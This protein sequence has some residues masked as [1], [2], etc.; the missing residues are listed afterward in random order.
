MKKA[1]QIIS[2]VLLTAVF[3]LPFQGCGKYEEGPSFSLKTK[4]GR[5][6]QSWTVEKFVDHHGDETTATGNEGTYTYEKDGTYSWSDGSASISGT[7]EFDDSKENI[8]TTLTIIIAV[9][10][11]TKIIKLTSSELWIEDSDGDQ[12]HFKAE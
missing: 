6:C 2:L 10:T 12:A 8:E 3:T 1:L 5:L 11:T 7:W 9:T 4:K